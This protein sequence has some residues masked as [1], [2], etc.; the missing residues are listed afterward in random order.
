MEKNFAYMDAPQNPQCVLRNSTLEGYRIEK[1]I[2]NSKFVPI[3][4]CSI[5]HLSRGVTKEPAQYVESFCLR[6]L[7]KSQ[8]SGLS[9]IELFNR[10]VDRLTVKHV[11]DNDTHT[12][13]DTDTDDNILL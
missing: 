6:N 9:L 10:D 11:S 4:R 2:I 8:T 12:E 7:L 13:S 1:K 5:S 3:A